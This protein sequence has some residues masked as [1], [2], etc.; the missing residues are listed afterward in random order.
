MRKWFWFE[1][2]GVI[3]CAV[4]ALVRG[5]DGSAAVLRCGLWPL[6]PP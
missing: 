6:P 3:F 2:F 1:R 4:L 5:M